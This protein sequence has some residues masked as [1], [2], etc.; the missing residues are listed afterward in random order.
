MGGGCWD[1][2]RVCNWSGIGPGREGNPL[3]LQETQAWRPRKRRQQVHL[4]AHMRHGTCWHEQSNTRHVSHIS[5]PCGMYTYIH[6]CMSCRD[7]RGRRVQGR[8]AF[9]CPPSLRSEC[10]PSVKPYTRSKVLTWTP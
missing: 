1:G 5:W 3:E 2:C 4:A 7:A 9:T 8:T 6:T 10:H